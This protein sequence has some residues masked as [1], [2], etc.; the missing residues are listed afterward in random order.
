VTI[1]PGNATKG[2]P[3]PSNSPG[4]SGKSQAFGGGSRSGVVKGFQP[5]MTAM[6]NTEVNL[7]I[8]RIPLFNGSS[9]PNQHLK[10]FCV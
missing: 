8:P 9:N 7:L 1:E 4:S 10:S 3:S 2:Q 5:F 6:L